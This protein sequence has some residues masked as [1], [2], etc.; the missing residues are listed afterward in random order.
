[1]KTRLLLV[2]LAVSVGALT[3]GSAVRAQQAAPAPQF[4]LGRLSDS[5]CA[6]SHQAKM[7]A[8]KLSERE[9][10]FACIKALAKYVLVDTNNNVIPIANQDAM[11]MPLYAGRPVRLSG[12]LRNGAIFVTRVEAIPAHLHIGH[13]M[14]NWRDT[15]GTRGFLPVAVDEARVAAIHAKLAAKGATADEMKLHVGHVLNALDPS[16]EPK[17]PGA[18]YGVKKATAGAIQHLDFASK[19]EGITANITTQAAPTS[20]ALNDVARWTDEAVGIAQK[21]R[22]AAGLSEISQMVSELDALTAKIT[23]GLQQAQTHMGQMLK[24]EGLEGAPR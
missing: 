24:G 10:L 3:S 22:A 20:G 13:V 18:G 12:E 11:G 21:A 23:A 2:T 1:M 5:M 4:F 19:A 6:G 17:G 7:A 8:A 14:T 9:C 15:P 16:L